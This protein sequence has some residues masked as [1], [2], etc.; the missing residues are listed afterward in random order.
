[1]IPPLQSFSLFN[2]TITKA[3]TPVRSKFLPFLFTKYYH[4]N[5]HTPNSPKIIVAVS[6]LFYRKLS[7]TSLFFHKSPKN[8]TPWRKT[9][10][11]FYFWWLIFSPWTSKFHFHMLQHS[12]GAKFFKFLFFGIC[13][14]RPSL[15]RFRFEFAITY[16]FE[17]TFAWCA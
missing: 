12:F 11:P 5:I 6:L 13:L 15:Y 10:A 2:R 14:F 16:V 17:G 9:I 3:F 8:L 1:M 7:R 4:K